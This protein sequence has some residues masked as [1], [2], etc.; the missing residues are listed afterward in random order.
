M[1]RVHFSP[2]DLAR[3]R[4]APGPDHLWEISNSIQTLQRRDGG[5]AFGDWR[6]WAQARLPSS[7]RQLLS[8]LLPPTGY[9]PD[10]LTPHCGDGSTLQAAV[11][12]LVSTP[13]PRLHNELARVATSRRLPYWVDDLAGG[14]ADARE[15]LGQAVRDY[16]LKTLAP[17]WHRIHAHIDADRIVRLHS[18]L[19]GGVDGLLS[20]LGPQFRW[21]PPV[22][23]ATYPVDQELW[24][25]GRGLVL[26]PSFFCWPTPVTLADGDLPPILVYPIEHAEDWT[27]PKSG[28]HPIDEDSGPLGPLLGHT[29]AAVL[30]AARTGG[31]TGELARLLA[32]THPAISQHVKVL[33][34]AGLVTTVRSAGRSLHVAT[35]QGLALLRSAERGDPS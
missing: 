19:D 1:L 6:R 34:A 7:C 24:L 35:A 33:R 5:H 14:D 16:H 4:M 8:P 13:S 21:R 32:V 25:K 26:Q 15:Q 20:G 3:V 10:F 12:A 22:L 23:E 18:L 28:R 29:R 11:E 9:S 2:E 30:R 31:T 27:R 17:F